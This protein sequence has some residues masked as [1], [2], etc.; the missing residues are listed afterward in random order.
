MPH[1]LGPTGC[2][3]VKYLG[4]LS[5]NRLTARNISISASLS[6]SIITTFCI[7]LGWQDSVV[8]KLAGYCGHFHAILLIL[9]CYPYL[10]VFIHHNYHDLILHATESH[11][12]IK[13]PL[14]IFTNIPGKNRWGG[15]PL[16]YSVWKA[17]YLMTLADQLKVSF[18][19]RF[20]YIKLLFIVD[21]QFSYINS[22]TAYTRVQWTG[23]YLDTWYCT[24]R[25]Q[26]LHST[27][28][29]HTLD[30]FIRNTYLQ[31]NIQT[32]KW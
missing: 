9:H 11:R 6:F 29:F 8:Y 12:S 31:V 2:D 30:Y 26:F 3:R 5:H 19:I 7:S 14:T 20:L 17:I 27:G 13:A 32:F 21:V 18:N 28:L 4:L 1:P 23:K 22:Y 15:R 25:I 16:L 10:D 24:D